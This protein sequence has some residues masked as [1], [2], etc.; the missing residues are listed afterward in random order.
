MNPESEENRLDQSLRSKFDDFDL[1]PGAPVWA[2]IEAR[3]GPPPKLRPRRRP[4]LVPLLFVLT[5][6]VAG[7]GGWLLPHGP[8]AGY[9]RETDCTLHPQIINCQH[10]RALELLRPSR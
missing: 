7:L 4:W 6:F 5:A 10:S 9:A 1:V 3:L 8:A 2:G